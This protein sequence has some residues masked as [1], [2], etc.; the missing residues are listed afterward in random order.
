[1]LWIEEVDDLESTC[2]IQ[3]YHFQDFEM[4]DAKIASALN[5]II[6]NSQ[7]KRKFSLEEHEAQVQDRLLRGRQIAFMICKLPAF[8][9]LFLT[10][11]TYSVLLFET[12]M[13]RNS[14]QDGAKFHYQ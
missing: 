14:I 3:G 7:S 1:M 2:S 6:Q 10:T 12:T 4:L 9:I 13:F 11:P 5:E 8:M